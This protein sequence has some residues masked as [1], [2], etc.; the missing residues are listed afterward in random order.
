M[1]EKCINATL[2]CCSL[3]P[4]FGLLHERLTEIAT[5]WS[6]EVILVIQGANIL[7]RSK[8][9]TG[10]RVKVIIDDE[11]GL[12]RAR[13]IGILA[14]CTDWIIFIDD[15][16]T[17]DDLSG[18]KSLRGMLPGVYFGCVSSPDGAPLH[19]LSKSLR[20]LTLL[21]VDRVCSVQLVLHRKLFESIGCLDERFGVGARYGAC[22]E[23]DLLIRSL[24]GGFS[25]K[26]LDGFSVS[27]PIV[28]PSKEKRFSYGRGLG[29][30]LC[31]YRFNRLVL[32]FIVSRLLIRLIL[33]LLMK[34]ERARFRGMID[35]WMS[36][37]RDEKNRTD[38]YR[39]DGL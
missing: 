15:D 1:E 28:A 33:C 3:N 20:K 8:L 9:D 31:K 5:V 26:R 23:T 10:D 2:V 13:N 22:E 6:V 21:T 18:L 11:T 25:V 39:M 32:P 36:F 12:S 16:V 14:A 37:Q 4:D 19:R 34:S 27:H 30:M 35:G 38:G 24:L 29:A 7:P 17:V